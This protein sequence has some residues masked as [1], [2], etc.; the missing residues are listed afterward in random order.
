MIS[1][2]KTFPGEW[3]KAGSGYQY[4]LPASLSLSQSLPLPVALLG[5]LEKAGIALGRFSSLIDRLPKPQHFIYAYIH[6][7]ATL[8][9]RIEGTQ[10]QTQDAFMKQEDIALER[11]DDWAEVHACVCLLYTSPSP[12]DRQKSRMPSSA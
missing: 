11:R 7:E 1:E 2:V 9:S 10:T 12:R 6:H 5:Q 8:S 4:F 3:R